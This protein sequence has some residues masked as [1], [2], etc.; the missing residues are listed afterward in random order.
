MAV[1]EKTTWEWIEKLE[2]EISGQDGFRHGNHGAKWQ[3][4]EVMDAYLALTTK[5]TDFCTLYLLLFMEGI[6]LN[7]TLMEEF[8]KIVERNRN[9]FTTI[10]D[11]GK[12]EGVFRPDLD[13]FTIAASLLGAIDGLF[14]QWALNRKV[15]G[16]CKVF[17]GLRDG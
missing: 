17:Q 2:E 5:Q 3:L 13:S 8:R 10:L 14:I 12:K 6:G 4:E 7:K 1:V 15:F 9:L 11:R 16:L